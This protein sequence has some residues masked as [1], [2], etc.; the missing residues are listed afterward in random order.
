MTE[1]VQLIIRLSGKR[2]IMDPRNKLTA[3]PKV[4]P[5]EKEKEQFKHFHLFEESFNDGVQLGRRQVSYEYEEK[6]KELRILENTLE[7]TKVA[8]E[9]KEV[10][11]FKREMDM[12]RKEYAI[13]KNLNNIEKKK[14]RYMSIENRHKHF[15]KIIEKEEAEAEQKREER[16]TRLYEKRYTE[17]WI[18]KERYKQGHDPLEIYSTLGEYPAPEKEE[19]TEFEKSYWFILAL[20]VRKKQMELILHKKM[21]DITAYEK[22]M[23]EICGVKLESLDNTECPLCYGLLYRNRKIL[24]KET[25]TFY[26]HCKNNP[27]DL[28]SQLKHDKKEGWK[29]SSRAIKYDTREHYWELELYKIIEDSEELEIETLPDPSGCR[30]CPAYKMCTEFNYMMIYAPSTA[31]KDAKKKI[32]QLTEELP[33]NA[34]AG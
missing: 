31:I 14:I 8:L 1:D 15:Q 28:T 16:M 20:E 17:T 26:L 13:Y 5:N 12:S 21:E 18:S 10:K 19:P 32:K 6:M 24:K 23:N 29:I 4:E 33:D 30:H 3:L 22:A 34:A 7:H 9:K 25:Q 11:L 2:R 27:R